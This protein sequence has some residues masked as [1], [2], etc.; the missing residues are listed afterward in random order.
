MLLV[1]V[2]AWLAA[3][4][5][6]AAEQRIPAFTAY[7][8]PNPDGARISESSGLTRWQ[9]PDL[10]VNWYGFFTNAGMVNARL[11]LRLPPQ[12]ES[13]LELVLGDQSQSVSATGPDSPQPLVVDFGALRIPKPGFHRFQLIPR[14]PAGK[15][16]G[17][18]EALILH[19][20][21]VAGA[22][23]NLKERRNAAS[24]H[25]AYPVGKGTNVAAFYCEVT[26]VEDP[27]STF[28]MA[29]GW[30]RGYFGMQVNSP[31]ERR[32]IFSV[33]DSGNEAVDRAKVEDINRVKLVR[34][35]DGVFSGDFGNE[36]TG[37]HSHLKFP[38]KTGQTQRFVVTAEPVEQ[39]FTIFS[40]YYFRPDRREWMLISSWKAPK[41]GAWLRGLHSFSENFWGSTGHLTRKA[42]FGNQWIRTS[43]GDW[44]ELTTATFSHDPT[45]RADRLDRFMGIENNQFFL[46]HGGFVAG[47]TPFGEKFTRP[48]GL[49]LPTDVR[50]L[51]AP[52]QPQ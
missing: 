42:L 1:W 33:W 45:G 9:G 52:P 41:E 23:F 38:W 43:T 14:N 15:P 25:L 12:T 21:P 4:S 49:S 2:V 46:S 26:A 6:D 5:L 30:H 44:T 36:G 7:L 22:H 3:S 19:G 47:Y 16:N 8:L 10:S 51:V 17:D 48:P 28:Y 20:E 29:C 31:T 18:V 24:V 27:T 39:T 50:D 13:R 35:G 11:A 40:G 32:V 34:K 37:G